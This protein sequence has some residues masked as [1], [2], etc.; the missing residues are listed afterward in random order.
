MER[1]RVIVLAL[2]SILAT[3][4]APAWAENVVRWVS[5]TGM[6]TWEPT[7]AT[8]IVLNGRTQV[9]EGLTLLDAD[10]SLRPALATSWALAG[11][12]TWRFELRRGVRF[13]DG[14]PLTAA[15]VAFS[16]DRARG[17]GSEYAYMLTSI[18]AVTATGEYAVEITT[19]QPDLLLPVKIKSLAIIS[20][21]GRSCMVPSC[22]PGRPMPRPTLSRT[23][24][25]PV[26]SCSKASTRLA[27]ARRWS[28]THTGGGWSGTR[29][30]ST[31]SSGRRNP[32]RSDAWRCC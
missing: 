6:S 24:T 29:T 26:R 18:A 19:K 17:E 31:G 4:A 15:D 30:T 32:T 16:L 2:A 22:R 7:K 21:R 3:M 1:G 8:A 20:G 10:L 12:A 27:T 11:P 25:A 23:R 14:S 13:H 28:G 9:Y 5:A